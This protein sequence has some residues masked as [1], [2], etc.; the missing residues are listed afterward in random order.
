MPPGR[1]LR[2]A[3]GAV[4]FG[5]AALV[6]LHDWAGIGGSGLDSAV[7]GP[8]Y[9][10]VIVSAGLACA[11]KALDAGSERAGWLTIAAAI[12]AWGAAEVYWT[13]AISGDPTPPFP[14]PADIGYLAFYPLAAAGVWLLVRDRARRL[15]WRLWMDGLIAFLGTAAL[16]TALIFEYV[17]DRTSGSS[18]QVAVTLA[19]PIGDVLMLS[20]VV[21]V[22]AVTRWRPGRTWMLLLCG[23]AALVVADVAFTLQSNGALPEGVWIEPIYLIGAICVGA[24]AWQ[25]RAQAIRPVARFD[26]WRELMIPG[27]FAGLM[28]VLFVLQYSSAASAFTAILT[29]ATMLAVIARLAISVWENKRLLTAARTDHLTAL[30][31]QGALQGDLAAYCD[32]AGEE[33]V[34]L[35]LLDLNGFKRY[36]DTFGHPAGDAMLK[37]L[38]SQLRE[39]VR[40]HGFAYRV[41][42]DEFAV[43]LS[44]PTERQPTIT[45]LAAAALSA[46]GRSFELS[47]AWGAVAIPGEARTAAEAMQLADV[48]MYAQ[49]ES[50]RVERSTRAEEAIGLADGELRLGR[51]GDGEAVEQRQ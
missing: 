3:I 11:L 45:K 12:F 37:R 16:G 21:G 42:G 44:C 31:N 46:R 18:F 47:A 27:L 38:G 29:A 5:G 50:R 32:R 8:I 43:V 28:V 10:A 40:G 2:L 1:A 49:K 4:L 20:L 39:A 35:V 15:D 36:N 22:I 24:E 33:P 6:A 17:A 19:Y 48:R 7:N 9:D 41:G 25:P 26:G 13:A 34:T 51:V 30:G 23:L 14:S